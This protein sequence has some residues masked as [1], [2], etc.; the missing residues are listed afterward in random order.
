MSSVVPGHEDEGHVDAAPADQGHADAGPADS[1]PAGGGLVGAVKSLRT[2]VTQKY[3]SVEELILSVGITLAILLPG[4]MELQNQIFDDGVRS[5]NFMLLLCTQKEFRGFVVEVL[6]N[7]SEGVEWNVT[8]GESRSIDTK[9]ILEA[10]ADVWR[11]DGHSPEALHPCQSKQQIGTMTRA[12]LESFPSWLVD[13]WALLHPDAPLWTDHVNAMCSFASSLLLG[14]LIGSLLMYFSLS[15][16]PT[17]ED[18]SG[19][20]LTQWLR[21][22]FPVVLVNLLL[23]AASIV[24]LLFA[25]DAYTESQDPFFVRRGRWAGYAKIALL[26]LF[27]P[28]VLLFIVGALVSLIRSLRRRREGT[29]DLG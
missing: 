16:S 12:I 29:R 11:W 5:K 13:T 25:N 3:D 7:V 15:A 2:L 17:R 19:R 21:V 23:L 1:S 6:D 26:A 10:G 18:T 9:A 8:L 4:A 22:G 14:A 20:A 24:V 28:M 27:T